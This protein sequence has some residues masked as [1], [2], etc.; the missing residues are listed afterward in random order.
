MFLLLS[1][2]ASLR[3]LSAKWANQQVCPTDLV[4]ASRC[5]LGAAA[6]KMTAR[7]LTGR[8]TAPGVCFLAL[9]LICRSVS[10]DSAFR[11][12]P[13]APGPVSF[14]NDVMAVLSKAG[15]SAGTCHGNKNGKGGF[16]LSL[17][18]QD[19]GVDYASLTRDLF[20]RRVTPL[21]PEQ[22]LVL[23]KP[24]TQIAHEGGLR[25]KPD[26][27][28]YA[29]LRRWI[30][31]GMP[32]DSASAPTLTKLD[33]HIATAA[34]DSSQAGKVQAKRRL[35]SA[36]LEGLEAAAVWPPELVV[37]EP[38]QS[39]QLQAE[40]T[41]SDGTIRDI[42]SLAVYEPANGQAK[43]S[44]DGRVKG[45]GS[46]ETTV[47]VRY[48]HCQEPVQVAFVPARPDFAWN[49][50]PANNYI[51]DHIFRKLRS[52]RMNA[53]GLCSDEVFVRRAHLDLLGI[54]PTAAEAWAFVQFPRSARSQEAPKTPARVPRRDQGALKSAATET[55]T[56][57][58]RARLV[59]QLLERPEF[60]DF[61]GLKWADLLRVETHSAAQIFLGTRLQCAECHNHPSDRWTQDDYYDWAGLFARLEYKVIENR[62]EIGSDR[63]EWNGEQ[64]IF[65]AREA[66]V[67][68]ARTGR[69]A[70]PRFLGAALPLGA[71]DPDPAPVTNHQSAIG[72][73]RAPGAEHPSPTTLDTDPFEALADWLTSPGN[74][75]FARVQANRIW[76]QLMGRGLVDPPDDFRSTNPASHPALLEALAQDL[77]QHRFDARYLIR[78]IM[79][80]R[81]YQLSSEPNDTNASDDLNYSHA[82]VRRLGA[83][84]LL[85]CQSQVAGVPLRFSG[86]PTGLRAAQLPG[87]RPESKGKRRVNQLDQFLELFGKP[88][89]LLTSDTERSCECNMGQA[90]QMISGRTL[91][92]LLAEKDNRVT[93]LLAADKSNREI[94][95]ELFWTALTRA[96]MPGELE[97]LLPGLECAGNRRAEFED[98][99]WGLLNSKDFVFRR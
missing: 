58:R 92:E 37:V 94:V 93:R 18:G 74:A 40:A 19:P 38:Q 51:D 61:W 35:R 17:R 68:N 89:R 7:C 83:E 96:P 88:P 87:V 86:Y 56:M 6:G 76:Y 26:S 49:E 69:N 3:S 78:L 13:S 32:D 36:P 24:T 65:L 79:S 5:A 4:G 82:L 71:P 72:N 98:I 1:P 95:E 45:E 97:S 91:N 2:P 48:L 50:T 66:S 22:S 64:I 23:L 99:L 12:A 29:I 63:H 30:A 75:L 42:S 8:W 39:V 16:K 25:F 52:L 73:H 54:L 57:A 70:Q 41:F 9:C 60:A 85:D 81:A 27:Q 84:Q 53:S 11:A 21:E 20:S 59:D 62:R 44:P 28:E 47:L 67:T 31:D 80:S 43:V 90:F 77:V 33:V 34:A 10:A 55:G 14:R 46:G 15:C